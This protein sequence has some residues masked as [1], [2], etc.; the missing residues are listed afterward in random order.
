MLA[1]LF[2][3]KKTPYQKTKSE[4]KNRLLSEGI[5][6]LDEWLNKQ[7]LEKQFIPVDAYRIMF[8]LLKD[9]HP[10]EA[11]NYGDKA[12][13]IDFDPE[14]EKVLENR[15]MLIQHNKNKKM[16]Y[17]VKEHSVKAFV[18]FY[19]NN[20]IQDVEKW[21]D[22]AVEVR[23]DSALQ[24]YKTFF[25]LA[26]NDYP[27]RAT[28][29]GEKA[30]LL[31][32]DAKFKKVIQTRQR[33]L[34]NSENI[35]QIAENHTVKLKD[36]QIVLD[37]LLEKSIED[38]VEYITTIET[39][40]NSIVVPLKI[41]LIKRINK[42][43]IP[44][45]I[46]TGLSIIDQL[47]N[48]PILKLLAARAYGVKDYSIAL[49]FY[50][51]YYDLTQD[52]TIVDRLLNCISQEIDIN[53]VS[54]DSY[55]DIVNSFIDDFFSDRDSDKSLLQYKL[56]FNIL[57]RSGLDEEAVYNGIKA[58]E[59]EQ[60][61]TMSLELS[62]TIFNL[63]DIT[64]AIEKSGLNALNEKHSTIIS[65]Y[66]YLKL[67]ENGFEF[68]GESE[69]CCEGSDK[70]LYVINN[71]LP[72]HSNGYATRAHG[73]LQGV[74]ELNVSIHAAT[75]LGYPHDMKK[76]KNNEIVHQHEIDS[77]FY[78]HL[79]STLGLNHIPL[80][81]Y[82]L[83]YGEKLAQHAKEHNI[84]VIHSAS[85][86]VNGLAANYAAKKL[87]LKSIYEVR[88]LWEITR[89]SRQPQWE[90]SEHFELIKKLETEAA[91]QADQVL[92][93]TQALKDEL[94]LRGVD[95]EKIDVLPN[96]VNVSA[97]SP[98]ENKIEL[99][100]ELG[101]N[102][103]D[104]V[105]GYIGS[106]VDY[107]GIELL[108]DA[109]VVLKNRGLEKFKFLLV[110]DGKALD[111]IKTKI[112]ELSITELVVITG[113]VP[114]EEVDSYYSLIDIAPFPRKGLPVCEMVSPLKP[115][116]AMAMEKTILSSNVSALAEIVIDGYNGLLFEKDNVEDLADKLEQLI[117]DEKLRTVLAKQARK[118]VLKERDWK[119][120]SHKLNDI[121]TG[122]IK[123]KQQ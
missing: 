116:E 5:N 65:I 80:S 81:D 82:L 71:S 7:V 90:N 117:G 30:I 35:E 54:I 64:G 97:F 98:M 88:G 20:K 61:D 52:N 19:R 39:Y 34:A 73:L 38:A 37:K 3:V 101:I 43:N 92:T 108:I 63:G 106:I 56:S 31:G 59:I 26:K 93:I 55:K 24:L 109:L 70:I 112:K 69:K 9:T 102:S 72:Y 46:S 27:K 45:T 111:S 13:K 53:E 44:E 121:Y 84:G 120:I 114:H 12:Q 21:L 62:K 103:D 48:E 15:R 1:K 76:F 22:E 66:N 79:P 33:W 68:S 122:L 67:K 77:I 113:R 94:I 11:V 41:H 10:S 32:A 95:P 4:I 29:Y 17:K 6:V 91:L 78:F 42:I 8:S 51:K 50:K 105:I 115:F 2:G 118:W 89:I 40:N 60:N 86:F 58:V 119:V 96:G 18:E 16:K 104:V 74:K 110:G 83:E 107:E 14:I 57:R 49:I 75:R 100:E 87:G 47:D 25:S 28:F 36:A 123:G 99:M 85:N 23:N